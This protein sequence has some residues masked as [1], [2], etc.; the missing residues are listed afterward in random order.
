[1]LFMI[2]SMLASYYIVYVDVFEE[3]KLKYSKI[4]VEELKKSQIKA[5]VKHIKQNIFNTLKWLL[6]T[7][8]RYILLTFHALLNFLLI[9]DVKDFLV[10]FI[11][12]I[13]AFT[14][15]VHLYLY[16]KSSPN[17]SKLRTMYLSFLPVF[18][19][20]IL[21]VIFRYLLFFQK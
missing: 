2:T 8:A 15:P 16:L 4:E 13:E 21:L 10:M 17:D 18:G 7:R 14:I 5:N 12:V 6:A 3:T 9:F 20:C 1:V 11:F 19:S